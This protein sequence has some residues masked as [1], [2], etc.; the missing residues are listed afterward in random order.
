[1][2]MLMTLCSSFSDSNTRGVT[3]GP[4]M[5]VATRA[6]AVR[7]VEIEKWAGAGADG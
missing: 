4:H 3:L 5:A 2:P 1:M 6:G 7:G